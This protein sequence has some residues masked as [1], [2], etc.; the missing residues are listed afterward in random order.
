MIPLQSFQC[1]R[2]FWEILADG[3]LFD[4]MMCPYTIT[5]LSLTGLG[6]FII[7]MP[8]IALKN[9]SESWTVPMTWLAIAV[10]SMSLAL[11]PGTVLRRIA[12][13]LTLMFALLFIGLYYW[14]G[15]G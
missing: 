13:V 11:L 3:R 4:W 12:G 15:R 5:G 8:F 1:G 9:W 6:V 2:P 10:P 14:W 7:G